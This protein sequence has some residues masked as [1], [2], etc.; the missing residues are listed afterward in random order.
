MGHSSPDRLEAMSNEVVL[1][2]ID[3]LQDEL[4][5]IVANLGPAALDAAE[6]AMQEAVDFLQGQIPPY[7]SSPPPTG[8][9][10]NASDKAK[11]WF[12]WA[13]KNDKLPGWSWVEKTDTK[14]AHPEGRYRQT[15]H[16]GGSFTT[17]VTKD[18][19][20]VSGGI[21]T[22]TP[23]AGWVVGPDFPGEEFNGKI[24]YQ[25]KVHA[26]RWWQFA[27]VINDNIEQAWGKF[28]DELMKQII[29][30]FQKK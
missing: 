20:S 15:G 11:R 6:P 23:Y 14:P 5:K 21:G 28:E 3:D 13:V 4:K 12:F 25:A 10:K 22:N 17:E 24:M 7:P 26:N 8:G 9:L 18:G 29:K 27:T 30:A 16:L 2:G 1:N 19:N